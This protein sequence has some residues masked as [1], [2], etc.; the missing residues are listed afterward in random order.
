LADKQ[1]S[2]HLDMG[3]MDYRNVI[4]DIP[5]VGYGRGPAKFGRI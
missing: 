5:R 3:V 2:D 4:G 1:L